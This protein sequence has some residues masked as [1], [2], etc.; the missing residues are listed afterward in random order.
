[1][2]IFSCIKVNKNHQEL[3]GILYDIDF[4]ELEDLNYFKSETEISD[5]EVSV[6]NSCLD[7]D[8]IK[9]ATVW[10]KNKLVAPVKI[11]YTAVVIDQGGA[12]DRVSDLNCFFMAIDPNCPSNILECA[13]SIRSGRFGDYHRLRTYYVGYGGHDNTTT[14]MR[15]Y[16]GYNGERPLLKNH[17]LRFPHIIEPN[18][19]IK[20]EIM[21][22][23]EIITYS[24]N[25]NI[26]FKMNDTLA[27]NE[28]WFG[29]RTVRNHMQIL[30]LKITN[31]NP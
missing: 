20:V 3:D 11:E 5:D 13:D 21:V 15:R 8:A 27:Y 18:K 28:G 4:N 24:H 30:D 10:F 25:D 12:N 7:I 26:I 16:T 9:G 17:D 14:R 2:S 1:M 19:P 6:K 31:L 23:K 22:Q 29:F